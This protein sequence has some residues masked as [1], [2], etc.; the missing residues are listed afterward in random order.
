MSDTFPVVP[1]APSRRFS[2]AGRSVL[3]CAAVSLLAA[4]SAL[5]AGIAHTDPG[6]TADS[7]LIGQSAGFSGTA[8]EEVKQATRGAQL[9]FD[10]V[11]QRGGVNGR[12]IQLVSIDDGFEPKRT[13]A[14]T[15]QLIQEKQV[16]ALFLYRGTPTTESVLPLLDE[17]KIPLVAPV[18]GATS[19]HTPMHRYLFN[20]RAKYRSEVGKTVE[21][22]STMGMQ[23]LGVVYSD[24]SFGR[25]ALEGLKEAV[26]ARNLPA[27]TLAAYTRNTT[28]VG[29]A[30]KKIKD[31]NPQAV[32]MFC[33]AKPCETFVKEYRKSGSYHPI[34]TLS[35]VS[36]PAFV[37]ALGPLA[38]GIGISQVFPS[39]GD[40]TVPISK[41][42]HLALQ[43]H[44]DVVESYP[45]LE[46][47]L[48]A[49]IL[50]EGL[51][52][53]G[54]NPTR[55]GLVTGLESMR[56][57]DMGGVDV[58]YS[59]SSRDGSHFVELTVVGREGQFLR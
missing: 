20:V 31:A 4:S 6:V 45:G 41:E 33:T 55:E 8:G 14:N 5:A 30:V 53:A 18:S 27:P 7:I 46:G 3:L 9:Y 52:R 43:G 48:S 47:F 50:V 37:K 19:L 57:A 11:N 44:K 12:K 15:K 40:I 35:N 36:S 17:Y 49:K 51:R 54:K 1:Q 26:K 59:P 16:F 22:I 38:R 28:A 42:F 58:N 24:D 21:Q 10:E 39:P 23:R 25:D 2:R 34:F 56:G 13:V 32:L 29:D